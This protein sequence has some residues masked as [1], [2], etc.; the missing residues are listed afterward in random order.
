MDIKDRIALMNSQDGKGDLEAME[1]L[2]LKIAEAEKSIETQKL[3]LVDSKGALEPIEA[4]LALA[5]D[6]TNSEQRKA[7]LV[8]ARSKD[9]ECLLHSDAI[10][11]AEHEMIGFQDVLK[12]NQLHYQVLRYRVNYKTAQLQF[13]AGGN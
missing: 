6:G 11:Q 13:L 4:R 10:R 3:V 5:V 1:D 9:P 2:A 8:I 12:V 7:H